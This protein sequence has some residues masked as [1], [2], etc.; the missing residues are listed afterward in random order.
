M[1][2]QKLVGIVACSGEELPEG[3]VTRVAVWKAFG[4]LMSPSIVATCLPLFLAGQQQERE[5]A[6]DNP[7]VTVEGCEK[8]CAE[9]AVCMFGGK[10]HATIVVT[11]VENETGLTA[12]FRVYLGEDGEKLSD[13]IAERIAKEVEEVLTKGDSNE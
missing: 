12:K 4:K 13:I 2:K 3:T 11:D 8:R 6:R 1:Q 10:P 5:F 9:K 7:I